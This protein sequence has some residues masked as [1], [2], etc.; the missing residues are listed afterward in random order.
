[1]KNAEMSYA[2]TSAN[3]PYSS[4]PA[5][6]TTSLRS[7]LGSTKGSTNVS[8]APTIIYTPKSENQCSTS[9]RHEAENRRSTG[10]R[11]EAANQRSTG[12]ACL[13][14]RQCDAGELEAEIHLPMNSGGTFQ[15]SIESN[16][17]GNSAQDAESVKC[18]LKRQ[19]RELE[20]QLKESLDAQEQSQ[21]EIEDYRFQF[22]EIQ[23]KTVEERFHMQEQLTSQIEKLRE[24]MNIV[25]DKRIELEKEMQKKTDMIKQLESAL[26]EGR[27]NVENLKNENSKQV[28]V[29]VGQ[30]NR[31]MEQLKM[32]KKIE[33]MQNAQIDNLKQ[34]IE[35][36]KH[37]RTNLFKKETSTVNEASILVAQKEK[38][39]LS[40]TNE[41]ETTVAKQNENKNKMEM[42]IADLQLQVENG[43]QEYNSMIEQKN[44]DHELQIEQ[45][46]SAIESL[47]T[48][49][50]ATEASRSDEIEQLHADLQNRSD[51]IE[52]K[53]FQIMSMESQIKTC[54][55]ETVQVQNL[56]QEAIRQRDDLGDKILSHEESQ[57]RN[58][59]MSMEA[60][61]SQ[62]DFSP[63]KP[64]KPWQNQILNE[65]TELESELQSCAGL[66]RT[67]G[68]CCFNFKN[69]LDEANDEILKSK[70]ELIERQLDS[71]TIKSKMQNEIH[72]KEQRIQYLEEQLQE[73]SN[74]TREGLH[75]MIDDELLALLR[76]SSSSLK[77]STILISKIP[78]ETTETEIASDL[79]VGL[80]ENEIFKIDDGCK[81]LFESSQTLEDLAANVSERCARHRHREEIQLKAMERSLN[82]LS[83]SSS[84]DDTYRQ[85]R[86]AQSS[87]DIF[88][89]KNMALLAELE[90]KNSYIKRM[91]E[92]FLSDESGNKVNQR[93][94][95]DDYVEYNNQ[96][97]SDGSYLGNS[98]LRSSGHGH[99]GNTN[100]RSSGDGFVGDASQRSSGKGHVGNANQRSSGGGYLGN[101]NQRSSGGGYL[102]NVNL[103]SSGCG[104]DG[105]ANQRSSGDGYIG[106]ASQHSS[107]EG[108]DNRYSSGVAH[109]GD[110]N[111]RSS[112]DAHVG[113]DNQRSSGDDYVGNNN[114]RSSGNDYDGNNNQRS[115]GND[116]VG[117][118]NQRSSGND[119]DGNNNQ[120]SSGNDYVGNNN[121]RSS[122][123][124]Y[125][126]DRNQR[127][128]GNSGN[129]RTDVSSRCMIGS[130]KNRII[131][132]V[133]QISDAD[134]RDERTASQISEDAFNQRLSGS[135]NL[136]QLFSKNN[137]I[138]ETSVQK[139]NGA[140]SDL[141]HVSNLSS[142][143]TPGGHNLGGNTHRGHNLGGNTPGGHTLG[144]N[145]PGGHTFEVNTPGGHTLG[146]NIGAMDTRGG[147][148]SSH[149]TNSVSF[150]HVSSPN[151]RPTTCHLPRMTPTVK[152]PPRSLTTNH[153]QSNNNSMLLSDLSQGGRV[154]SPS[155]IRIECSVTQTSDIPLPPPAKG[156][157][158]PFPPSTSSAPTFTSMAPPRL[159]DPG[160][161]PLPPSRGGA[162]VSVEVMSGSW[163]QQNL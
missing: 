45:L 127:S 42:K 141:P 88:K 57:N 150:T 51:L 87:A 118:N 125:V 94:S 101:A 4:T 148:T 10:G 126:G 146:V 158:S 135:P 139:T 137:R 160:S 92:M 19:I 143:S 52:D 99:V 140:S 161:K 61:I 17:E 144:V 70:N 64:L 73:N 6:N 55:D 22:E 71:D 29:V 83:K 60:I 76:K 113:D 96:R 80:G 37:E 131:A 159:S 50:N 12:E 1:M 162:K 98:N 85:L 106:K 152:S 86:L 79:P 112:G 151:S 133:S 25:G 110:G 153:D 30:S 97:T 39:L 89:E 49:L 115:S 100:Q 116:Y 34:E 47:S 54:H 46:Q 107:A 108:Y 68:G 163:T 90:A 123:N 78:H 122:G 21:N 130:P 136:R 111:Q 103:R 11:H 59:E 44:K 129:Q 38:Q 77:R 13:N 33:E 66:I 72:E 157:P 41:L 134:D 145:T 74:K 28:D 14:V 81:L 69:L 8:A 18:Q 53:N 9:G 109:V 128:S 149:D 82:H 35:N 120:R 63:V 62:I 156:G 142:H 20:K 132:H 32:N 119:Y 154:V 24:D 121:Q 75:S 3:S 27:E 16:N 102:G 23:R 117:N 105:N 15:V 58:L 7:P 93:S 114:Q 124:D 104:Y 2:S 65:T 84:S 48:S 36:L 138:R 5:Q 40:L 147:T 67:L 26:A 56:L 95:D 43:Q 155:R 91:E 31:L